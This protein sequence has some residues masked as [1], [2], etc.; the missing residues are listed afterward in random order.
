MFPQA[1]CTKAHLQEKNKDLKAT[2]R[3]IRDARKESDAGFDSS[4]GMVT[5]GPN[6]TGS[7][8]TG[9]LCFNSTN[10]T[11]HTNENLVQENHEA[12]RVGPEASVGVVPINVAVVAS[13]TS[14]DAVAASS[15]GVGAVD[16][17]VDAHEGTEAQSAPS[18][19]STQDHSGKKRK[20]SQVV[21]VLDDYLD[22]KKAQSE[23]TVGALLEKKFREEEYSVEKCLDTVD[24]MSELT[25][26]DKAITA[27]VFDK[28]MNREMFMKQKNL[29]QDCI[30]LRLGKLVQ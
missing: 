23:K 25:D 27:E 13:S 21:A 8:A 29:N 6:V 24:G 12:A 15:T 28:D 2:Y 11:H 19:A 30:F 10:P 20:Q 26:E 3:A 1:H 16:P 14:M 22:H 17:S 18:G 9:D 5:G 7:I 4:S